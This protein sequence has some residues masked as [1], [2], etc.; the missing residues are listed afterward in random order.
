MSVR[1]D[2]SV[3]KTLDSLPLPADFHLP[4][5]SE[6]K[7]LEDVLGNFLRILIYKGSLGLPELIISIESP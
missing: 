7:I 3:Q 2:I 1:K 6:K 5:C 4:S